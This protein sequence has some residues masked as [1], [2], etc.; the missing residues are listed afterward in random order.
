MGSIPSLLAGQD[1]AF[2]HA[3]KL[4]IFAWLFMASLVVEGIEWAKLVE[5]VV[6][7]DAT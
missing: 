2:G 6:S 7:H 5:L 4:K 1:L 3:G